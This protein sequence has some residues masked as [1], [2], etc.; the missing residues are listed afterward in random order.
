[1]SEFKNFNELKKVYA[2]A[3][4]IGDDRII[5]NILGNR[6]RLVVRMVF[7]YMAIQIKWFGTHAE[8]DRTDVLT[9]TVKKKKR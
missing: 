7:D 6:F 3:S 8:Y 4:L 5:F 1:V 2:N 9:V